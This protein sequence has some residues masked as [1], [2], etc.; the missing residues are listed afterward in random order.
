MLWVRNLFLDEY[1]PQSNSLLSKVF[2]ALIDFN[3]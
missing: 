2:I 1:L 3:M